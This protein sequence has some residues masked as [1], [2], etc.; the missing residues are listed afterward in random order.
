MST[1]P[2]TRDGIISE[3]HILKF[4]SKEFLLTIHKSSNTH[5]LYLGGSHTYCINILIYL[6]ESTYVMLGLNNPRECS[7][8]HFYYS[9]LCSF[10]G[11]YQ[12]GVDT[13]LIFNLMI[14]FIKKNYQ[15]ITTVKLKDYSTRECDNGGNVNLYEMYYILYGKTWYQAKYN[16]YL[17]PKDL[18][19][20][21]NS[22]RNFQE[23]KNLIGWTNFKEMPIWPDDIDLDI[24]E[25][26]YNTTDT[27][28]DFFSKI[29]DY[30]TISSF[31]S[32]ILPWITE[33]LK[34]TMK[35]NFQAPSYYIDILMIKNVGY[36]HVGGNKRRR[37]TRC[38]KLFA[39]VQLL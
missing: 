30:I 38:R 35:Y 3:T 23:K 29:R 21:T 16:A 10:S 5:N 14:A 31:C 34:S 2:P 28:Q 4:G 1:I 39:P 8:E 27:W 22:D 17:L 15:I 25:E 6:P 37:N 26:Y 33:F 36:T 11:G 32:F 12:R 24:I 7:V 13:S 19:N 20:F 18:D 9:N